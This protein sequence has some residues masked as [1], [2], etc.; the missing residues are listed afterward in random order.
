MKKLVAVA[1][2]LLGAAILTAIVSVTVLLFLMFSTDAGRSEGFFGAMFFEA[3]ESGG[4]TN[5]EAGVNDPVPLVVLFVISS[6]MIVAAHAVYRRLMARRKQLLDERS[7][8]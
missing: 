1:N 2:S 5:V 6:I 8:P 3:V 7:E 4:V